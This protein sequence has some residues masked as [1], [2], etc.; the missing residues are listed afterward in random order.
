MFAALVMGRR[1]K[2]PRRRAFQFQ[3]FQVAIEGKIEIQASLFAVRDDIQSDSNLI[4][5]RSDDGIVFQFGAI[6]FAKF[7]QVTARELEPARKRVAADDGRAR[8]FGLHELPTSAYNR[9]RRWEC[10]S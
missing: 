7:A 10:S 3:S 2:T 5:N 4:M 6:G 1:A 9:A 8:R